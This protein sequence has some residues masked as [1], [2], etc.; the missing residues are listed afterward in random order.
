[1]EQSM[2]LA[3]H[4]R[5]TRPVPLDVLRAGQMAGIGG[6]GGVMRAL[7]GMLEELAGRDDQPG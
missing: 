5:R 3:E 2:L 4:A 6:A 1:M 7:N